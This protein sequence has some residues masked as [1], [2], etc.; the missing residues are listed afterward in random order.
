MKEKNL[1]ILRNNKINVPAFIA[2]QNENDVDLSFTN[3]KYFAVRSSYA[4]EDK[5]RNSYAGQFDT[6]L[7]VPR[8]E[9][10]NAVSKVI[11]G[12][13]NTLEYEKAKNI[14]HSE[15]QGKHVVI[16][17]EM[18]EADYSGVIFTANPMGI[19]NETVITIGK[20][21]GNGVVEDK[22]ET[23]T[24]YYNNDEKLF[25]LK[26]NNLNINIDNKILEELIKVSQK[27]KYIFEKEM[28]IAVE[29][30]KVYILQA[31]PITT[32]NSKKII[33]LD[34][35]NIVESYPGISLPA[36][37]EFVHEIYS[38]IF[39]S[40]FYRITK[41]KELMKKMS[42]IFDNMVTTYNGSIYYQIDN[43]YAILKLLPFSNKIIKIWQE[44]LGVEN[45]LVNNETTKV[46][47][48]LKI[49]ILVSFMYYLVITPHSMKKL[50][51]YF[52]KMYAVYR[53][54]IEET[55]NITELM[56]LLENIE[57]SITSVWDITLIND[58]YAF[59]FTHLAGGKENQKIANIKNIESMKPVRAINE[60]VKI[61]KLD[62]MESESY[63]KKEK[64]YIE[65]YGDRILEELKLE[66]KTYRSNPEMLKEYVQSKM[67]E[68]LKEENETN[69][70]PKSF[71]LFVKL[72]KIGISN[73]EI[74]RLNRTRLF[75][76]A[77]SIL[78]K[79]GDILAQ[80]GQID[81]KEDV[82]YL[83]LKEINSTNE[84]Q[85]LVNKR[86]E[87][88]R[89]Y[90]NIYHPKRL[91][92]ANKIIK[93]LERSI[94]SA[95]FKKK[96]SIK[97]TSTSSGKVKGE[98]IVINKVKG[99]I[100]TEGKIIVT[101]ST[102]PGWIFLLE[103][104]LGIIAEQGSILSHTAIIS[105]EL[106]KPAIVN[107]KDATKILKTGD[108]VELDAFTG[109]INILERGKKGGV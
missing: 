60:L 30:K 37:Q 85:E 108:I 91:V 92:F 73:R 71:N 102:D 61:A 14:K 104:A 86:K 52:D 66:T 9:V 42:N 87:E 1:E 89:G 99:N 80:N 65:L 45:K 4:S 62:G 56:N 74:S 57:K 46:S 94:S 101:K 76:L 36:T 29:E 41:N 28:D 39:E 63:N 26:E 93:N 96:E 6:F 32:I 12:Y 31:R 58:M 18:V 67:N 100:N 35:S 19:L 109:T 24:Y 81:K 10:K 33:I 21:I 49:R 16:I 34:N 2:V 88:Y 75:G 95:Q 20:G 7:N 27:I 98:V 13:N 54:K 15:Y 79:V 48:F 22:V 17:Q 82:F 78:L 47:V 105:R 107:V 44:M 51:K 3:C 40:C 25:Y 5:G 97:G 53:E 23:T 72:A 69:E 59:I 38:D 77:R 55:N 90:E 8:E 83:Y 64:E 43:W 50:N 103:N 70:I 68:K 106:K 11:K 84:Y